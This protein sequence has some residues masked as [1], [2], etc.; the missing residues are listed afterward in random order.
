MDHFTNRS[1]I[2]V[3]PLWTM[4]TSMGAAAD[5]KISFNDDIRPIF[6]N[7][8]TKCHGGAKADGGLSLIY[9]EQALGT[10]ESGIAII[11]PGKPQ[12]SELYRRIVTDDLDDKMPLQHGDHA[13]E[14]LSDEQCETIK[15][16]IEQGAQW[17]DHWAYLAPVQKLPKKLENNEWPRNGLDQWILAKL[18][19]N[20]LQP[21]PDANRAQWLR[22]ASFD[23]TG[24]PPTSEEVASFQNDPSEDAYEKQVD[25]LL[26]SKHYGER[27][28]AVWMDLAR[29]ADTQGYEKDRTRTIW[30]YR[31]YLIRSFNNDKPYDLFLREQLAGDLFEHPSFDSLIATAF[32]RNSQTNTEGGTDDEEYRV[33]ATI[34]RVNTTWTAMQ[35]LTFGCIQCHAHPYEPI[36]HEDYYRFSD[37]FNSSEDADLDNDYP[38][39]KFNGD[40]Q[41]QKE[42]ARLFLE[43]P[44]LKESVNKLGKDLL[45]NDQS[46]T[47]IKFS[48]IR[49]SH[50][51]ITQQESG[52]FR[53]SGTF[54]PGTN[55][56][57]QADADEITAL[58]VTITPEAENPAELPERGSVLSQFVLQV[59]KT[60]G[61]L[62][63]VDFSNVFADSLSGP[64]EPK[65]SLNK[66][67]AGFG[68]YPKLFKQREAVFVLKK[69]LNLAKGEQISIFIQH[70]AATTGGQACTLRR[71]TVSTTNNP[72]WIELCNSKALAEANQQLNKANS[73]YNAIKGH[74]V[75]VL[76]DR[77][78]DA[79]R[80]TRLFIGGLWLNKGDIHTMGVPELLNPANMKQ[81]NRLEMADWMSSSTNPLTARVMV[82][83]LFAELFGRGIV[84]TLG[85]FGSTGES[86]TNLELLDHLAVEFQTK[87]K[88][89]IKQALKEMVLSATYRQDNAASI[90]LAHS[91]PKNILLA[92]GPRTRL[93]AEMIRDNALA[94]SGLFTP[95]V[96]GASVMPP[97]P[98]GIWQSV[99]SGEKWTTAEGPQR[100]RRA[101]YPFWKRTSPYPSMLTFDAPSRD[102]CAPQRIP[103]NTPLHAL[104]TL[105]DPVFLECS[106]A[107][108]KRLTKHSSSLSEQLSHGYHLVSQ[109]A[110]SNEALD[111]LSDLHTKVLKDFVANK[112][113]AKSIGDSPEHAALTI[114]ANTLLNLDVALT[115]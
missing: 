70:R 2:Y 24:L 5:V 82:N 44:K 86:P 60:D 16:W 6:I 18:E 76:V 71:F 80:E 102:V 31:D 28:A 62:V 84:A 79:R 108:A 57:L 38:T 99:Y 33:M 7:K 63:T 20:E 11:V 25:R 69:P 83:R 56:T 74:N 89:S 109:Q 40:P 51:K 34:D 37:Y 21:S 17:D 93:S 96:G 66:S 75:P 104:T 95:Q 87:Q 114:I 48:N 115:K 23:L 36:P 78:Q 106:Q 81:S 1:L 100:Y 94:T 85:D 52:E 103:T 113:N 107:L 39:L 111:A 10:G 4:L 91:D 9:R 13:D 112:E 12:E 77:E 42:A 88:W 35:G 55:Y 53:T 61:K 64:Y 67:G 72:A 59:K 58:K 14:P 101:I 27:W 26:A 90:E 65:H 92:R 68:G 32:H 105:N 30:P 8:C 22:R 43:L 97:Q 50:G 47:P 73:A 45:S 49:S 98:D 3:I 110:I 29:Y 46:F 19:E 41:Q 54:P 15:S